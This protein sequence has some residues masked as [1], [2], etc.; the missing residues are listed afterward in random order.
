MA[1]SAPQG[2]VSISFQS[3]I[4]G[5]EDYFEQSQ[6]LPVLADALSQLARERPQ[7]ALAS[8]QNCLAT[9]AARRSGV[10]GMAEEEG[11]KKEDWDAPPADSA[12]IDPLGLITWENLPSENT[13][14]GRNLSECRCWAGGFSRPLLEGWQPQ[15]SSCCA[16]ASVA[17]AFNALFD[18]GR[19]HPK[20]A[21]IAEVAEL[22]AKFCDRLNDQQQRRIESS[23]ELQAGAFDAVV[24]A[25]DAELLTRGMKWTTPP[26][27]E[28]VTSVTAL[29]VLRELLIAWRPARTSETA[30]GSDDAPFVALRS[31]LLGLKHGED[32]SEERLKETGSSTSPDLDKQLCEFFQKRRASHRL[33]AEMHLTFDIGT[34]GIYPAVA[35]LS[36][37]RGCDTMQAQTLL[38]R[39]ATKTRCDDFLPVEECDSAEFIDLQWAALKRAFSRPHTVLLFHL[40]KHYALIYAWREWLPEASGG[41]SPVARRRQILTARK[42][43]EPTAWMDFEEVRSI[44]LD[45]ACPS[46]FQVLQ[47]Q[48]SGASS[49]SNFG[50]EVGIPGGA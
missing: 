33:R 6:L 28:A 39:R 26:G 2:S 10:K 7:D 22:M 4:E 49:S 9:E 12:V 37:S 8:L 16:A 15:P 23:L 11:E 35:D 20:S 25:L 43:Q 44:I 40:T 30:I 27:P 29:G 3:A 32:A 14:R 45:E 13:T 5:T 48:R 24:S 18:L 41:S 38:G 17:G 36:S 46:W 21:S 19:N 47:V 42:G 1:M 34:W 50:I 31:A